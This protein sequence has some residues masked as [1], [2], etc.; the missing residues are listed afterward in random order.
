LC[1]FE[2]SLKA[3]NCHIPMRVELG[4]GI[5]EFYTSIIEQIDSLPEIENLDVIQPEI[6]DTEES[7]Q[8][9]ISK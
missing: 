1:V 4:T 2:K 6:S 5:V 7:F 9:L 8:E 3:E